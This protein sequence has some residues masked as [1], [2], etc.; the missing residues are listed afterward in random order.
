VQGV[1][2]AQSPVVERGTAEGAGRSHARDLTRES[3][4]QSGQRQHDAA[5]GDDERRRPAWPA[6]RRHRMTP[7]NPPCRRPW[8]LV[9]PSMGKNVRP[10]HP[11]RRGMIASGLRQR[12]CAADHFVD[13]GGRCLASD[14]PGM[15]TPRSTFEDG[16]CTCRVE[17]E[18]TR[19]SRVSTGRLIRP[20]L[21]TRSPGAV[22]TRRPT[23]WVPR[24]P[25]NRPTEARW[26]AVKPPAN[27][28]GPGVPR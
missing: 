8:H 19:M 9:I 5:C 11:R 10:I 18:S 27:L 21:R 2:P 23:T 14:T 25:A 6:L 12:F 26:R 15:R 3:D 7:G 1:G 17:V 13:G 22:R 4:E 16:E 20:K 24:G 28:T